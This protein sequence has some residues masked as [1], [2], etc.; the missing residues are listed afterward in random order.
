MD[1]VSPPPDPAE[2][3]SLDPKVIAA[4]RKFAAVL[5]VSNPN[6]R[7]QLSPTEKFISGHMHRIDASRLNIPPEWQ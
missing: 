3:Y 7:S 5:E 1:S 4:V 6:W 2:S